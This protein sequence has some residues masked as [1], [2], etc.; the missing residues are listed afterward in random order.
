[1]GS[2][3]RCPRGHTWAPSGDSGT[4]P[5]CGDDALPDDAAAT[6]VFVAPA[7][8]AP[9]P[10][11]AADQTQQFDRAPR[12][13]S[14][15]DL[16]L[17]I[18][19]E[20]RELSAVDLVH[21]DCSATVGQT[22]AQSDQSADLSVLPP[23][24]IS[25][26]GYRVLQELGRGGMGVVYKAHQ[27]S[28]NRPVALKMILSGE[29]AGPT[30]R[31][32]FRR[33]AESVAA[34]QHPNIVQIFEVGEA[35][36][37]PYLVLEFVEGGSLAERLSGDPWPARDAAELVELLAR[38]VHY[39]H[40]HGIVHRDLKPGNVLLSGDRGQGTGD[41]K[42]P[43]SPGV[44][45]VSCLLS[46]KITDFGLA[47]RLDGSDAD[48]ATKTGAVVGT[49]GYIAPEQA[50]GKGSEVGTPADVYALGAILYECL[51]GRPPFRGETPLDTV[52]Q[53]MHD[54]PVPPKRLRSSV[55]RDLETICLK[56]L[57]KS[58][59]KRYESAAA[60][61]DDLRRFLAGEPIWARPVSAWGRAVKW[62]ARHPALAALGVSTVVA[63]VALLVVL[64]VAYARVRDAVTQ[65]EAE[66]R[67]AQQEREHAEKEWTRAEIEKTRAERL[68]AENDRQ[69]KE[70]EGHAEQLQREGEKRN[71]MGYALQLAQIAALCER[72]P[73]RAL[74]LL[75]DET[76][77]PPELRDFTWEYLH[78]LC[79]RE[80]RVYQG[81]AGGLFA[82]AYAPG[83]ALVATAGLDRLIRLW[84]PRTGRT[85][86][87]L[88]G[89]ASAVIEVAFGPDG[90]L[91]ASAGAD[92]T[93][94]LWEI[95]VEVFETARKTMSAVPVLQTILN[96]ARL[97]PLV[98]IAAHP[99]GVSG[100]AFDPHGRTLVSGGADG[101]VRW[102]DL[103]GLRPAPMELAVGGGLAAVGRGLRPD[104]RR[105]FREDR[106]PR[107]V[108]CLKFD[109]TG[110]L[111]AAGSPDGKLRV[112]SADAPEPR[113][114]DHPGQILAVAFS[115]DGR[116]VAT[117]YLPRR[118]ATWT[119]RL[120][121]TETWTDEHRLVGHN[122]AVNGL[123]FSPD[124][125]FLASAGGDKTV[126][127]WDVDE[128]RE[129]SVL[130]G[131]TQL[132]TGVAFGPD[133][134][135][136]VSVAADGTARVWLTAIRPYESADVAGVDQ[137]TSA[138]L[139]E[140]AGVF[141]FADDPGQIGI[142]LVDM[143]PGRS[144]APGGSLFLWSVPAEV[145]QKAKVRA[146][147]VAPRGNAVFGATADA[148]LVWRVFQIRTRTADLGGQFSL[149]MTK[150]VR[151]PTAKPVHALAPNHDGRALAALDADGVRVWPLTP[152]ALGL[153]HIGRPPESRLVLP[154]E[155]ATTLAAH[156]WEDLLAVALGN[157]VR[158]ID[159]TGATVAERADAH[160]ARVTAV[161]FSS[162][163][164]F[165]AT[166]DAEGQ[167]RV[168]KL[169]PNGLALQSQMSGH[170]GAVGSLGFTPNGKT[171]AS[172]GADRSVV[173]WDPVIGQER[174]V[175][176][177]H[178]DQ[179]VRVQF[180]VDGA[181]LVS[182]GRDGSVRRWRAEPRRPT[183]PPPGPMGP[184]KSPPAAK[185]GR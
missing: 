138:G 36:G 63:T 94:R 6:Q 78:R 24:A 131:H 129:R 143:V 112:W 83:G 167:V 70:A 126:R 1:M 183:P 121:S 139:S 12:P 54:D 64:S 106:T 171:L 25:V 130:L 95:P 37:H 51:T 104:A 105:P 45:A 113:V 9:T 181:A 79:R 47:K 32:R 159:L 164:G 185:G 20:R 42:A 149:P 91:L 35:N 145:P 71:R 116:L 18:P 68:A 172:G 80:E 3:Y 182:V 109:P 154:V 127:L 173:L 169:G 133:R 16:P 144:A 75:D 85:A 92:G 102:W 10:Q 136:F 48:K 38:A 22:P 180:T 166:G 13:D 108:K 163:H 7:A 161:A 135:S 56:C 160:P 93:V 101:G 122:G 110:K 153:E 49:P 158:V 27:K 23:G 168:W 72:D 142:R 30:E 39:A 86:A 103:G 19:E 53:V 57:T 170:S 46:P 156:P 124:G 58:P 176:T 65:K 165:L 150:P 34:L 87:I 11:D 76:R 175:L 107:M 2:V 125:Q 120:I 82:V 147:A 8:T 81:H 40:E 117:S 14:T 44:S 179:V 140:S 52:L 77:C 55:P 62:A 61:A 178:A 128:G 123:A 114:V 88:E 17:V 98:T 84:D 115:P 69:R 89:H 4:C 33:E 90:R 67:I 155:K 162:L 29:H 152:V 97:R 5:V 43:S 74:Q 157:G 96:P 73:K 146:T 26:P 66:A 111:L 99:G 21:P 41:S 118:P 177:G 50:S 141:A 119:I 148:I 132:A 100:I 31:E 28:L 60:L 184:R 134:R 15:F 174:A 151:L 59:A 137:V